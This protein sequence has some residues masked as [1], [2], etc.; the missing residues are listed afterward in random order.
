MNKGQKISIDPAYDYAKSQQISTETLKEAIC[1]IEKESSHMLPFEVWEDEFANLTLFVYDKQDAP[2]FMHYG[3][4][5][6][7]GRLAQAVSDLLNGAH[8]VKDN[9][10]YCEEDLSSA[11]DSYITTGSET[12][13]IANNYAIYPED[14]FDLDSRFEIVNNEFD[15]A[16]PID[17]DALNKH[18]FERE[19]KEVKAL[20]IE[21]QR[22]YVERVKT[23]LAIEGHADPVEFD[24][25]QYLERNLANSQEEKKSIA[26]R[27]AYYSGIAKPDR[28]DTMSKPT[29]ED[30]AR[31]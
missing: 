22:A 4:Q 31:S 28:G 16:F 27:K 3:I 23:G 11:Y 6:Q 10:L 1:K 21:Q 12:V 29:K 5:H 17:T 8:P 15:K 18:A 13:L 7:E 2:I 30:I 26:D 9:W 20:P 19:L 25:A 24:V 14:H